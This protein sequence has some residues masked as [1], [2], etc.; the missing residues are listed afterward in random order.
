MAGLAMGLFPAVG[1]A[2]FGASLE[3]QRGIV[4]VAFFGA[5]LLGIP[6]TLI[7]GLPAHALLL[8]MRWTSWRSYAVAG[9][10]CG[11]LC[12]AVLYRSWHLL[13]LAWGM[14]RLSEGID[15]LD[16]SGQPAICPDQIVIMAAYVKFAAFLIVGGTITAVCG[17]LMRR[18]DLDG[19]PAAQ[20]LRRRRREGSQ[21]GGLETAIPDKCCGTMKGPRQGRWR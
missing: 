13:E 2:F 20:Q 1:L 8:A 9:G 18:P 7:V 16:A 3:E 15:C 5:V 12:A 19:A 6:I 10:A 17:W 14:G 11:I 4:T 21:E